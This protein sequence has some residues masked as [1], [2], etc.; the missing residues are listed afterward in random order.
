[1]TENATEFI[2]TVSTSATEFQHENGIFP[3]HILPAAII[4]VVFLFLTLTII[5]ALKLC[6]CA[7]KKNFTRGHSRIFNRPACSES[8]HERKGLD[9]LHVCTCTQKSHDTGESANCSHE[10]MLVDIDEVTSYFQEDSDMGEFIECAR[11]AHDTHCLRSM[12]SNCS[13]DHRD[14]G[15]CSDEYIVYNPDHDGVCMTVE[16]EMHPKELQCYRETLDSPAHLAVSS[17]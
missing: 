8:E 10:T 1:M 14:M 11:N 3:S 2:S 15:A 7:R 13:Y 4:T 6:G 5:V 17:V 9:D 12:S 16:V